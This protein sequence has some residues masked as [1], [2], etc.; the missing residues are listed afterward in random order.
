MLTSKSLLVIFTSNK[1]CK[2][3]W[4]K[5]VHIFSINIMK[6]VTHKYNCM[7]FQILFLFL[8]N[9]NHFKKYIILSSTCECP[10]YGSMTGEM[11]LRPISHSVYWTCFVYMSIWLDPISPLHALNSLPIYLFTADFVQYILTI[12][13]LTIYQI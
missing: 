7:Y 1:K 6:T 8:R 10:V 12:F 11:S 9:Y 2:F 3:N 4:I 5:S 13:Y